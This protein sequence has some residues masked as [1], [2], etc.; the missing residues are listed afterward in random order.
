MDDGE[1]LHEV[2]DRYV[3]FNWR[4]PSAIL[5]SQLDIICSAHVFDVFFDRALDKFKTGD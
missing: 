1:C 2:T 3:A 5:G 4:C